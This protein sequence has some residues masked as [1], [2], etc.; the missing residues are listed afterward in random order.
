[1]IAATSNIQDALICLLPKQINKNSYCHH[2]TDMWRQLHT[3]S[4]KWC[5]YS[6]HLELSYSLIFLLK[7]VKTVMGEFGIIT[8]RTFVVMYRLLAESHNTYG[9]PVSIE[10]LSD[11]YSLQ[12]VLC[13]WHASV[14]MNKIVKLGTA[15]ATS[16]SWINNIL[17]T[18][19]QYNFS[20]IYTAVSMISM[21]YL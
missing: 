21:K 8:K 4:S 9:C 16:I 19:T 20:G 10:Q 7:C 2:N 15:V 14:T 6:Y 13:I 3:L 5:K 1:M 17:S 12:K 11:S 18:G